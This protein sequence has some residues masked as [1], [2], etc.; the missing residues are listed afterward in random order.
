MFIYQATVEK[1]VDGDTLDLQVDL[2]FGV[3]TRQRVRLLGINAAEHGTE[4]GDKATAFVRDWVQKHGPVFT[5]RTQKD[6]REKYG[7][8]LATVLSGTEDLGQALIDAGL[9]LP[10]DGTGPRPVPE[11][12][13]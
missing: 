2:G 12:V 1:V 7:R 5:V 6:K 11:P 3:F 13:P 4:L 8:Y 9:A 10:Y